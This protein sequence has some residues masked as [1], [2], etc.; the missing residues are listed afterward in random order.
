MR[1]PTSFR[2]WAEMREGRLHDLPDP[3][4]HSGFEPSLHAEALE[5]LKQCAA[6]NGSLVCVAGVHLGQIGNC[7]Q[8]QGTS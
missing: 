5:V 1:W 4:V 6:P 2:S 7:S 3:T 8:H